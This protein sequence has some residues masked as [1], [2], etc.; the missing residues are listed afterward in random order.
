[1]DRRPLLLMASATALLAGLLA[2]I[3]VSDNGLLDL[4][5]LRRQRDAVAAQNAV[6]A[7]ENADLTRTI[8][9][10]KRDPSYIEN[11]ARQE[12]G[13]IGK[14]EVIL[15]FKSP[16]EAQEAPAGGSQQPSSESTAR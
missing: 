10:L 13:V 2:A 15:R 5:R 6:I 9:R 7:R 11:I 3:V 1:M 12:L 14:S 8:E 4:L 16:T